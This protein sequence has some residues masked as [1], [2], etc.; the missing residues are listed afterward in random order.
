M[1]YALTFGV[2]TGLVAIVPFFGTLLSTTLPA[3]FVLNTPHGGVRALMVLG[4]GV[5]VH[6]VEGNILS[7][8]IMSKQVEIPPVLSI[9][10]VLI[11]GTLLGPLGLLIALPTLCVVK[12]LVNRIVIHGIYEGGVA[13]R[14]TPIAPMRALTPP[15]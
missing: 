11:V 4:V 6:L 15:D 13:A 8:L 7:P 12:V 14:A 10:G 2:F 5:V 9:L 1:P 3:L